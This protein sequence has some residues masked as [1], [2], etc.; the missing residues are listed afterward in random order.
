MRTR[1]STRI[2]AM[3][4]LTLTLGV[5]G[6]GCTIGGPYWSGADQCTVQF[7]PMEPSPN[8]PPDVIRPI[9]GDLVYETCWTAEY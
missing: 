5:A 4:A 6:A 9:I 8:G 7:G 1:R 3:T 2:A